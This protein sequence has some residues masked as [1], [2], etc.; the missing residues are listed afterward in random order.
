MRANSSLFELERNFVFLI[1]AHLL[2][3][4]QLLFAGAEADMHHSPVALSHHTRE[5]E[6]ITWSQDDCISVTT[7]EAV[8]VL[9]SMAM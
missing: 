8:Y 4:A 1:N 5:L 9:V 2:I 3:N 6:A 7:S